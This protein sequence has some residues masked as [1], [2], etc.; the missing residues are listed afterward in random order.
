MAVIENHD[1]AL[2]HLEK[3]YSVLKRLDS[4]LK[5]AVKG[6]DGVIDLLVGLENL[7]AKI[8]FYFGDDLVW[9]P[10]TGF[11]MDEMDVLGREAEALHVGVLHVMDPQPD[12]V[13]AIGAAKAQQRVLLF[14]PLQQFVIRASR[15]GHGGFLVKRST[16]TGPIL[17]LLQAGLH[18]ISGAK[19]PGLTRLGAR[20]TQLSSTL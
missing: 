20:E 2:D 7:R 10:R 1:P 5:R 15:S 18:P 19:M 16:L 11:E 13:R 8:V 6:R 12:R 14:E 3:P 4:R 17:A 9:E